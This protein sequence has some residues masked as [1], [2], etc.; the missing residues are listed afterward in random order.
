MKRT[1]AVGIALASMWL[2]APTGLAV[3]DEVQVFGSE[4]EQTPPPIEQSTDQPSEPPPSETPIETQPIDE[5]TPPIEPQPV[6]P[7]TS[8]TPVETQPI[9]QPPTNETQPINQPPAN[10]TQ[11]IYNPFETQPLNE[12]TPVDQPSEPTPVDETIDQPSD[13]PSGETIDQPFNQPSEPTP[14]ETKPVETKP[15][16]P[17]IISEPLDQSTQPSEPPEPKRVVP[18]PPSDDEVEVGQKLNFDDIHSLNQQEREPSKP[19]ERPSLETEPFKDLTPSDIENPPT[20]EPKVNEAEPAVEKP[21]E[22]YVEPIDRYKTETREKD[23]TNVKQPSKPP[24]ET[25]SRDQTKTPSTSQSTRQQPQG[26]KVKA[27]FVK[28]TSDDTFD[29]YLDLASVQWQLMPYSSSEYMA[30]IWVRM[31]ERNPDDS[32]LPQDLYDYVNDRSSDEVSE[33]RKKGLIYDEVDVKVLRTKK[34]FLEH[35][36]IRPKTKQIQFLCELEVIGRPQNTISERAY[37][38]K[39]WENLIPGSIESSIY[40]GTLDVIGTSKA[41][42]RGHM[43]AAD[44]LEE[45]AR[46]SIR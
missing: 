17:L 15:I 5:P 2:L 7:P 41:T 39:N 3:D 44:M 28:L 14:V 27:R 45:Y 21:T 18:A 23:Q 29:Y 4:F 10:E 26:K 20:L 31:I 30:D 37:S 25:P 35:Y 12:T 24:K 43:T 22:P 36:Y 8:E 11:P 38:Y 46:I 13:Q 19:V 9:N 33:A 1:A 16:E 40:S 42:S 32:S 6:E 34:Y